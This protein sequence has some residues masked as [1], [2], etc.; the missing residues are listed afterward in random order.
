MANP[1]CSCEAVN[2]PT[3]P[4][5][6]RCRLHENAG[7]VFEAL[8]EMV[9]EFLPVTDK[10]QGWNDSPMGEKMRAIIAKVEGR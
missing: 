5:F 10:R 9:K 2:T 1:K 6:K 7:E 4:L 8:K 3:G